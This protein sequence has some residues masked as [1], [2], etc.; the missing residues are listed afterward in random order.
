MFYHEFSLEF[1]YNVHILELQHLLIMGNELEIYMNELETS[2]SSNFN[3][4]MSFGRFSQWQQANQQNTRI[5]PRDEETQPGVLREKFSGWPCKTQPLFPVSE[6][7]S[8]SLEGPCK[9]C[10]KKL[11]EVLI[12]ECEAVKAE[13]ARIAAAEEEKKKMEEERKQ[14]EEE[15]KKLKDMLIAIQAKLAQ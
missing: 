1:P 8:R 4:T 6:D 11:K 14:L 2:V 15:N 7:G 13:E 9:N 12:W 5:R 3:K 10:G